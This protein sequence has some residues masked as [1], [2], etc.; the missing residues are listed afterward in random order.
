MGGVVSVITVAL[1]RYRVHSFLA[2]GSHNFVVLDPGS[3]G[4]IDYLMVGGGGSSSTGGGGAGGVLT[5]GNQPVPL[6]SL[7]S[8]TTLTVVVSAGCIGQLAHSSNNSDP[9]TARIE[10][11]DNGQPYQLGNFTALGGGGGAS[12]DEAPATTAMAGPVL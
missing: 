4:L 1:V 12:F 10:R 8:S 9:G 7:G 11:G 5:N 6:A 3:E 2:V